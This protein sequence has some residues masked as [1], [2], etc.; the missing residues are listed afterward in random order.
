MDGSQV[1]YYACRGK[2]PAKLI[3]SRPRGNRAIVACFDL[4]GDKVDELISDKDI[5]D[6][7]QKAS[8]DLKYPTGTAPKN[9]IGI[10][11]VECGKFLKGEG[12]LAAIPV[13]PEKYSR[14]GVC[15]FRKDG[16]CAYYEEFGGRVSGIAMIK[17]KSQDYLIV[18]MNEKLLIYP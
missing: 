7:K 17:T 8:V 6:L 11:P 4:N 10:F 14:T 3:V 18:Q 2:Q 12:T 9:S 15:L 1:S 16:S 5:Y 13:S